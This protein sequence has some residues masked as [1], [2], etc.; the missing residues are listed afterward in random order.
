MIVRKLRLQKGWSQQQLA[1]MA[2][3]SIRT[4]QRIERGHKAGLES[5]KSLAA[6]FEVEFS[7]LAQETE[8]H[9]PQTI[10]SEEQ[11]ALEYVREI[12]GFYSHLICYAIIITLLFILNLVTSPGYIW[13]GWPA[14][15]WGIGVIS[16]GVSVFKEFDLLG[17]DWEKRQVEKR[18][19]RKL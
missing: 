12:K 15:G 5:I 17:H 19:G 1:E 3:L 16:H 9:P 4:I 10:T 18:L 7:N 11:M 8:M 14:M 2:G 6:V 13:A